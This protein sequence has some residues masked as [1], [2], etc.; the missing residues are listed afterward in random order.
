MRIFF[1]CTLP[2]IHLG[3]TLGRCR[4][5]L[6]GQWRGPSSCRIY[7]TGVRVWKHSRWQRTS[8]VPATSRETN[9]FMTHMLARLEQ[10]SAN[11]GQSSIPVRPNGL[12]AVVVLYTSFPNLWLNTSNGKQVQRFISSR[13]ER[14]T[15]EIKWQAVTPIIMPKQQSLRVAYFNDFIFSW[16]SCF[17]RPIAPSWLPETAY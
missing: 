4:R 5:R 9:W 12:V 10:G 11:S 8:C 2:S 13:A 3:E 6:P 1:A 17:L 15:V 16:R 14:R 7:I